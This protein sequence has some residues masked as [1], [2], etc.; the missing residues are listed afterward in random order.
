M[1]DR[2]LSAA[3][4]AAAIVVLALIVGLA[5]DACHVAA[6]TTRYEWEGVPAVW[7]SAIWF[8]RYIPIVARE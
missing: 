8:P 1:A 7:R 4:T 5:G 6:G 3:Q 2:D